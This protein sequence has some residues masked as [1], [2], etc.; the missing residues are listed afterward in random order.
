M[1]EERMLNIKKGARYAGMGETYFRKWAEQIG[2][3][4]VFSPRMT[5]YDKVVID[6]ALDEMA[7]KPSQDA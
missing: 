6:R 1:N 2:A 7:Q 3:V 4:R 5:R